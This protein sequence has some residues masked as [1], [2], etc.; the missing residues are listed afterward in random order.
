MAF[1]CFHIHTLTKEFT[2][3]LRNYVHKQYHIVQLCISNRAIGGILTPAGHRVVPLSCR[4]VVQTSAVKDAQSRAV[5]HNS[6]FPGKQT[7]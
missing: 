5:V 2:H 6:L 1:D 3:N 7:L 4:R